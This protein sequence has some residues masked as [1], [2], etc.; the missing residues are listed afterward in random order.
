MYINY[1]DLFFG[2]QLGSQKCKSSNV[3]LIIL[4]DMISEALDPGEPIGT[5]MHRLTPRNNKV[6]AIN[7][8]IHDV[9]NEMIH[10]NQFRSHDG[11]IKWKHFPP[12]CPFAGNRGIPLTKASDAE[13]WCFLW[14]APGINGRVNSREAGDLIRHRSHYDLIVMV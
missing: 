7:L 10:A 11:V 1:H 9:P 6:N 5:L 13:H 4:I 3:A 2:Y 8:C 12:N 14:S